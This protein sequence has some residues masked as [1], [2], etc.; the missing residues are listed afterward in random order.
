MEMLF[1]NRYVRT[2]QDLKAF[3]FR[4]YFGAKYLIIDVIFA[5]F[6]L[7]MVLPDVY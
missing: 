3:Y 5:L 1:E 6:V 4:Y 2:E 7:Y